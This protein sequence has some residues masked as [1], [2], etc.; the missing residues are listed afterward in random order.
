M[1]SPPNSKE[2]REQP[3]LVSLVLQS[4]KALQHGEQLCSKANSLTNA[5]AQYALDVLALDAKVKWIS[6]SVMEQLKLAVNVAKS[7]EHKR[8]LLDKQIRDWDIVRTERTNALDTILES[9]G[10]QLV[11]PDFHQMSSDSSLFGSQH[12]D[13]LVNGKP[14][15]FDP[16]HSPTATVRDHT[17]EREPQSKHK[18][19]TK[20][21]T[22]RDFVDDGAIED[23][24][25][26]MEN[27]RTRLDDLAASTYDY[28]ETLLTAIDS[29]RDSI[30]NS[31]ILPSIEVILT[32]QEKTSTHMAGHLESLA[33]HYD[34]MASALR[35][36]EA[37][38]IFS[39]EDLQDMNRDT[40]E[41]PSIMGE[42]EE[43]T[44]SIS[45]A[46]EQLLAAKT[47]AQQQLDAHSKSLDDLDELGEIMSEML[48][49]Q[50]EIEEECQDIL[51]GLQ[52]RLLVVE[53]LHH[54]YVLYQSS[55]NK[56]LV[57]ISRRRQY[58][59][60]ADQ[61]V[62][63]MMAKLQAMTEA[64]RKVR[65]DFNAEHGGHIPADICLCIE[66]PPTRWEVTPW[67]GDVRETLPH[68]DNDLL[69][70]LSTISE[71]EVSVPGSD[72]I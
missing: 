35:E 58:R 44:K 64:E 27:E 12:S 8:A 69:V 11:P 25:D 50:Q 3:H 53:D 66:T 52:Q 54:R 13:Q 42:L 39:E 10:A 31:A 63:G 28:P 1:A 19:R 57:E 67:D 72:S 26:T 30:L 36:S 24:L 56:L 60:E 49:K 40:D 45:E 4:K 37:G 2:H 7:I 16:R 70:Q 48:Q 62:E 15:I 29:I 18:D 14:V 33:G 17:F 34:Q 61:I 9:L 21:K 68:I 38:E 22:L 71:V 46:S 65:E 41:L 43:G 59:E 5:S 55:F 32:A 6:E 23:V 20:W 47:S 51:D